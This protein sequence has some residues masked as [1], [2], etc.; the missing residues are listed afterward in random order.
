MNQEK[1]KKGLTLKAMLIMFALIPLTVSVAVLSIFAVN[2][3]T[4]N[5]EKTIKEELMIAS[6]G[7]QQWYQ[8]DLESE[9]DLDPE[10]H[11]CQ[12]DTSMIDA[13]GQWGVDYT[14]FNKDV[15]FMTTI[16][17]EKTGQRIE[18]TKASEAVWAAVSKGNDYYSDDVVINGIDYYVYYLPLRGADGSIVG[19]AFSGKPATEVQAAEKRL[20]IAIITIGV[21]MEAIFFG[22][23]F[24]LANK[25]ANPIK[26]VIESVDEISQGNLTIDTN[27]N[28]HIAET[29]MLIGSAGRLIKHLTESVS[30]IIGR[31]DDIVESGANLDS[32]SAE[33]TDNM[34][35]LSTAIEEIAK[36]ATSM[37]NNVQDAAESVSEVLVNIDNINDSV[38]STQDA[39]DVMSEDSQKVVNDFDV[40]IN[41]TNISISKLQDISEKMNAVKEAVEQ[42]NEAAEE[43]NSI[44]SQTNLLSLNASIEAARAGE[45]GKGFAVVAG[46]ISNLSDQSNTAAGTIKD[47]MSNLEKQTM[48]AVTSV[49][50]LSEMMQKQGETSKQ[51]QESLNQLIEAIE[52][53]KVQVEAVK[54]G[55]DAVSG[56]CDKLNEIIQNL[57]A[58]SE[59]NAASA[60]ETS[61]SIEQVNVNTANIQSMAKDLNVVS[62]DLKKLVAYFKL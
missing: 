62:D 10:T 49:S 2:I 46:E 22:I 1:N 31:T 18:G 27:A 5:V 34:G 3:M 39:T 38:A 16:R 41:D 14:L 50:E 20:Y 51:S 17:D 19:M 26:H 60:E 43:I 42:V 36:G 6:G 55:S 54:S 40:L 61:A 23:A 11:F 57:S 15:R 21:L 4:R 37:A 13:M 12:Y 52:G 56:L 7:L 33:N 32:A 24:V 47:I 29:K 8:Y 48:D 45:A 44:A 58:I 9:N 59:E 35:N 25:V 30:G 53:T 28:T